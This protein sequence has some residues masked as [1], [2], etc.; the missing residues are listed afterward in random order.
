MSP[1]V[2][3]DREDLAEIIG[4]EPSEPFPHLWTRLC[5]HANEHPSRPALKTFPS[6]VDST[7]D[8]NGNVERNL[9]TYPHLHAKAELLAARLFSL[10]VRK[11]DAIAA[12]LDSR[13][14]W[15]LLFWVAIRL[16]AVFVPLNPRIISSKEEVTHVLQ[17]TKPSVLAV[18]NENDAKDLGR[19]ALHLVNEVSTRIIVT[20]TGSSLAIQWTALSDVMATQAHMDSK[21]NGCS[22]NASIPPAL[23][24]LDQTMMVIFTSGTTSLPKASFSTYQN[25][26]ASASGSITFRH[27]NPDSVLLQQLPVFHS[28]S[29]CMTLACWITGATVVYPSQTFDARASLSAIESAKCTHMLAVP[30]MIQALVTYPSLSNTNLES[31]QS[32]DLAGTMILPEI[33][34]ACMD[35][36]KAPYASVV[37]GMTEGNCLSASDTYKLPFTR[38]NIPKVLPCGTVTPGGRLRVCRPNSKDVLKRGEIGELHMGGLQVTKGYLDR[39]SDDFYNEDGIDWLVTGDQA[40]IDDRDLVYIWG[41]YKDVIIRGGEN[42]SPA[43]IEQCLD[44]IVGIK[45]SQVIGIPDEIAG[46]VPVAIVTKTP[47][48]ALSNYQIQQKVSQEL[49]KIF[50]PRNIFDLH[51]DLELSDYPRTTSGKIKKRDLKTIVVEHM[52]RATIDQRNGDHAYSTIYSVISIWA[53][54][55]GRMANDISP[56]ERA[57]TFA[58][59]IMMMQ[60]CNIVGKD[61]GKSLAVEDLIGDVAIVKQAQ[62]IDARPVITKS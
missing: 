15:A 14:E 62:I 24:N 12:F 27:L 38:H 33:I 20:S 29:V 30:S 44:A 45:D 51:D 28:W 10:G 35:D 18:L 47:E 5:E 22:E 56:E 54:V 13:A 53:R 59:S 1:R 37:Y 40:Q 19:A 21:S 42:I 36:L 52:A 4:V 48:L 50:S 2:V 11:D 32:I 3:N 31:L 8:A 23:N 39:H 25:L 55:S 7:V 57:D 43:A 17:V 46:E 61:L 49:G 16:D 60:F 34:K 9:W 41:R 26:I 6:L 58:D